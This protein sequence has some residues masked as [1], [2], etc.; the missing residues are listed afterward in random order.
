MLPSG[1]SMW[2]GWSIIGLLI[3]S[4]NESVPIVT[5]WVGRGRNGL[6]PCRGLFKKNEG[7]MSGKQREW[8]DA[9]R[10]HGDGITVK[11]RKRKIVKLFSL[12]QI[13][14]NMFE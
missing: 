12:N 1:P 13:S 8:H 10:I 6:I 14:L 9:C 4:I 2:R 5:Q 11:L 7:W 3:E